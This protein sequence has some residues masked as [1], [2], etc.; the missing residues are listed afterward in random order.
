MI[1]KECQRRDWARHKMD[2]RTQ[3]LRLARLEGR[4][5]SV[6]AVKNIAAGTKIFEVRIHFGKNRYLLCAF[7]NCV[8][9][10]ESFYFDVI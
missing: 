2:C 1:L 3:V 4:G 7:S 10:C 8:T 6:I 5:V 9:F